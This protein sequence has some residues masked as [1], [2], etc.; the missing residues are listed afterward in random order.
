MFKPLVSF[1]LLLVLAHPAW[2][3]Y[4]NPQL[5]VLVLTTKQPFTLSAKSGLFVSGIDQGSRQKSIT[6]FPAGRGRVRVGNGPKLKGPLTVRARG[7]IG[8]VH[9]GKKRRL[10]YDGFIE[11]KPSK[12]GVH[13]IN[14]IDT[15]RYLEGVIGGEIKTSWPMEAVKAQAVLAR[16]FALYRRYERARGAWHLKSGPT[17]QVYRGKNVSDP[18]GRFAIDATKGL[19]V[20]YQ[21]HLAQ[22]FYHANCGGVTELPSSLW[23]IELPYYQIQAVPY[24]QKAPKFQWQTF[25][26]RARVAQILKKAGMRRDQVEFMEISQ[27]TGSGRAAWIDLEGS[28]S[29]QIKGKDFRRHAGYQKI[30]SLLFEI[31]PAEGGFLL[32]GQ[33]NGHGIGMCQWAAK[34]MAEDGYD[35]EQILHYFYKPINLGYYGG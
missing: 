22:T 25:L 34:E 11:I 21:G 13:L 33:G 31:A 12:K 30:P 26:S 24:G 23:N 19:V 5:K 3:A 14:H 9:A 8:L 17:D 32:S 10:H 6:F 7:I 2:G 4:D 18:R 35:Y 27:R 1:L 15:E 29:Q 28:H 16:T 20:S